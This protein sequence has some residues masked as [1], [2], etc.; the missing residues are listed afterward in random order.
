MRTGARVQPPMHSESAG[1]YIASV[2]SNDSYTLRAALEC[3]RLRRRR[4]LTSIQQNCIYLNIKALHSSQFLLFF[5]CLGNAHVVLLF[6]A[7]F[8][9]QHPARKQSFYSPIIICSDSRFM[10]ACFE[11]FH[12]LQQF[13]KCRLVAKNH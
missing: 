4:R 13:I 3:Y 7:Q 12:L 2:G 5:F 1:S 10:E 6:L 8:N 9:P 11:H